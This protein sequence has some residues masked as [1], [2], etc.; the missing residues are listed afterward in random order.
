[1]SYIMRNFAV[2]SHVFLT[3]QH[4]SYTGPPNTRSKGPA[5]RDV[6]PVSS[7]ADGLDKGIK[8]KTRSAKPMLFIN[9]FNVTRNCPS[10]SPRKNM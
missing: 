9:T 5:L 2:T 8:N 3:S 6:S 7:K 4:G 1:M 10:T